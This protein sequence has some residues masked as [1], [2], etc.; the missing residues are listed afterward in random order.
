[1]PPWANYFYATGLLVPQGQEG[2]I[3][4]LRV[5]GDGNQLQE[6]KSGN[7]FETVV[8]YR[9]A[10]GLGVPGLYNY[11][12]G[13]TSPVIQPNGS[14]NSSRIRLFQLDVDVYPLPL[15]TNYA[16]ELIVYVESINWFQIS[17]GMG[18]VK[19]AL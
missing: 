1:M 7:W 14:I 16:Y 15:N 9:Y 3:R 8:P 6:E 5:L 4:G 2:I 13:L 17:S 19:Y 11:A 12:F 10:T 18:G